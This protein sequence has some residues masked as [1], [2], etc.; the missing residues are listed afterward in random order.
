MV[1][2]TNRKKKRIMGIVEKMFAAKN[3]EALR[4][5]FAVLNGYK[6]VSPKTKRRAIRQAED[7]FGSKAVREVRSTVPAQEVTDVEA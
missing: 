1:E 7:K 5:L 3:R 4:E 2:E 6:Y